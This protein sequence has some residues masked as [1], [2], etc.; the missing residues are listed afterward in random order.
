MHNRTDIALILLISVCTAAAVSRFA[1]A[2]HGRFSKLPPS[3]QYFLS[4]QWTVTTVFL[5]GVV[6]KQ[7]IE[8]RPA[9]T[10]HDVAQ[11]FQLI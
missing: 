2:V 7:R 1:N 3:V 5:L 8:V 6:G 4:L 10:D 9:S 11:G